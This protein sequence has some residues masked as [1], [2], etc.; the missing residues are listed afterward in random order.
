M[1]KTIIHGFIVGAMAVL[2]FHQGTVL[3]LSQLGS[4]SPV[5]ASIFGPTGA[6]FNLAPVKPLGVPMIVSQA[7]WG[8]LWGSVLVLILVLARPPDLLFGFVFGAVVLTLVA[9]TVVASLKGLPIFGGGNRTVW[10]RAIL[11]NG[12]WGWGT[13]LLLRS[14]VSRG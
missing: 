5:L 1:G 10:I 11:L 2:V 7:F 13:A 3:L 4:A 6:P 12:A 8:G 14:S 9:V